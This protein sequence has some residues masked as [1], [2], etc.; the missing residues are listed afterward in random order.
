MRFCVFPTRSTQRSDAVKARLIAGSSMYAVATR[1][2][3]DMPV[4]PDKGNGED[5]GPPPPELEK[6]APKRKRKAKGNGAE[7][8]LNRAES[9]PEEAAP[10]PEQLPSQDAPSL[11]ELLASAVAPEDEDV[12]LSE[13]DLGPPL[14]GPLT[15]RTSPPQ[16]IPFRILP[17]TYGYRTIYML[18]LKR[19]AQMD[20]DLDTYPLTET[21]RKGLMFHPVFQKG[22][23]RFEVRLGVM[24]PSK[25]F[26]FEINLDDSGI[27]GQTRRDLV[28]RAEKGWVISTSDRT[29]GYTPHDADVEIDLIIP[30]QT[31]EELYPLTYGPP[32]LKSLDHSVI[33][34]GAL[35]KAKK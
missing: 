14:Y 24:F 32:L 19:E 23:K 15:R 22:V 20:G 7:E 13:E 10:A 28:V 34:R 12:N 1:M 35:R 33:K 4:S 5:I 31:F 3:A 18:G 27:Y 30:T 29:T 16:T 9:L 6:S 26:F 17:R 25:P 8:T 11:D 2:A 21:V